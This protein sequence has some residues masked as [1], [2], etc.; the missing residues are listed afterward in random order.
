[1]VSWFAAL[2]LWPAA[3]SAA[4]AVTGAGRVIAQS[5]IMVDHT[6]VRLEGL[7][8]AMADAN[9]ATRIGKCVAIAKEGLASLIEGQTITCSLGHK[10]AAAY[11]LGTCSLADGTD[12]GQR[13]VEE[14]WGV[15]GPS[16][17][18]AYRDGGSGAK[19]GGKGVWAPR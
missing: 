15:A 13:M 4:D 8:S 7:D 11:F 2:V 14:G 12:I 10:I 5:T 6:R 3:A 18:K 19:S 9:C 16:A 17:P 1:M